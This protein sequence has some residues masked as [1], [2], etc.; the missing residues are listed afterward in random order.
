MQTRM[1]CPQSF[2]LYIIILNIIPCIMYL[3]QFY[4]YCARIQ[5]LDFAHS[6]RDSLIE[7]YLQR[8]LPDLCNSSA[9][10]T[11]EPWSICSQWRLFI[12]SF[13]MCV[14]VC[15]SL[16]LSPQ[17]T[18]SCHQHLSWIAAFPSTPALLPP[19]HFLNCCQNN[20]SKL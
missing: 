2:S 12:V 18:S 15:S 16:P 6:R 10:R 1:F 19:A 7:L 14:H 20:Y 4:F 13:P 17:L 8:G 9:V 3:T 11:S 5:T